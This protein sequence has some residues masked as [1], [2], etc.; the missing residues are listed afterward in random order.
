MDRAR[1]PKQD[2]SRHLNKNKVKGMTG[3]ALLA[4]GFA[5][6][7]ISRIFRGFADWYSA[8]IY[9]VWVNTV[10]R[11]MG[12]VRISVSE[13][14]L[15][16]LLLILAVRAGELGLAIVRRNGFREKAKVRLANL[17][18]LAGMLFFLYVA[19][20]GINY[21][22]ETFS[23]S[24]GLSV[25][26]YSVEELKET[27]LRLTGEVNDESRKVE[28]NPD[29][30]MTLE[31]VSLAR[32]AAE[33]MGRLGRKYPELSGYYPQPKGLLVPWILSVQNLS[34]IYSP[35]AVEANYNS[36]MTDYNIPFT[37]CHE[38]SHLR[39]F[40]EEKE[41]N[42]I[43]FLACRESES[44]EFRYSGSLMGWIYCMN[45]LYRS[46]YDAWEEVRGGLAKEVEADL[47]ANR[48]FWAQYDGAVAEVANRVND[49]YLKANGQ[50]EGVESYDRMVDLIVWHLKEEGNKKE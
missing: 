12:Y 29:G 21:R 14:L 19:N 4:A 27:C 3:C 23:E 25:G 13:V 44:E 46:D 17:I 30:T 43:G 31:D 6:L 40:M 47:K 39:G 49:T 7:F 15:Y 28:R 41:A 26:K 1:K 34:G 5:L 8:Y 18:L 32:E 10:G 48:E 20:C 9:P 35:F 42:F 16:L 2:Q 22:R 50:S 45:V 36:G 33:A 38:L 37:A 11:I 24:A